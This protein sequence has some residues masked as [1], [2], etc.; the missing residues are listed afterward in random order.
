MDE[1]EFIQL[2]EQFPVVRSR[3]YNANDTRITA[4]DAAAWRQGDSGATGSVV[5]SQVADSGE[6]SSA[7][8]TSTGRE[9]S[10]NSSEAQLGVD[11]F[12]A[13]LQRRAAEVVGKPRAELFC[14]A[15]RKCQSELVQSHLSLDDIERISAA[16]LAHKGVSP[17]SS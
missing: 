16:L 6:Q 17:S 15:F 13:L 5:A 7:T 1:E 3:L 12:W 11:A 14:Q 2:L 10:G 4:E 9:A 8:G